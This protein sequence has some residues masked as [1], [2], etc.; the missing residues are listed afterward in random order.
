MAEW[1]DIGCNLNF[2]P[3]TPRAWEWVIWLL[4]DSDFFVVSAI[5]LCFLLPPLRPELKD[6]NCTVCMVLLTLQIK[7]SLLRLV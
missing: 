4:G 7:V 5:L 6:S 3:H 2:S 1:N